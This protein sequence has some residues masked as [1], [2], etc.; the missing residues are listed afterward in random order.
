MAITQ[1]NG[2]RLLVAGLGSL[3]FVLSLLLAETGG[4]ILG[5]RCNEPSTIDDE[6]C[7]AIQYPEGVDAWQVIPAVAVALI[8]LGAIW[9][10]SFRLVHL[11]LAACVVLTLVLPI[12]VTDL[13]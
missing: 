4:G 13:F 10:A 11:A 1:G 7:K 5:G 2:R 9:R 12:L 6:F 3:Y 8:V